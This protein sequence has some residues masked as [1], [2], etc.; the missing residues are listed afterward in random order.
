MEQFNSGELKRIFGNISRIVII[1]LTASGRKAWQEEKETRKETSI[2]L[3][4]QEKS[5][6]SELFQVIQD[7]ISLILLCRTMLLF[8]AYSSST[9]IMSD[10]R[11]ICI[12]SSIRDWYLEVMQDS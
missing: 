7:A 12:P 9:F 2:V 4:R 5:C 6:T 3:I 11:S 10:V 8:R 1:G